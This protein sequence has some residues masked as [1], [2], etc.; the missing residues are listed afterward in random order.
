MDKMGYI[1]LY[2]TQFNNI[3]MIRKYQHYYLHLFWLFR[4]FV[5]PLHTVI[6]KFILKVH[7]RG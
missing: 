1:N 7:Y 5:L 4:N 3:I 6:T 2:I